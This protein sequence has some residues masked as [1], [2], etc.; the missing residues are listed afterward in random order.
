M[1]T[2]RLLIN[3]VICIGLVGC[4]SL[5]PQKTDVSQESAPSLSI[6][7]WHM[8]GRI[9]VQAREDAW[10]AHIIWNHEPQQDRVQIVGP[11]NQRMVSIVIREGLIYI[12]EGK[13]REMLSREPEKALRERLGFWVPLHSMKYWMTGLPDPAREHTRVT[14]VDGNTDFQQLG[15]RVE[16]SE[17]RSEN[18]YQC[19]GKIRIQG[20]GLKLK[21]VIDQWQPKRTIGVNP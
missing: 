18:G 7:E 20:Q 12:N 13:G 15:W 5:V 19:P 10:H 8:E 21:L 2:S 11:L 14:R 9:G 6:Q 4:S 3:S 16:S 1:F 17:Y